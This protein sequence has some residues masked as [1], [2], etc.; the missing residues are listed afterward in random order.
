MWQS[1]PYACRQQIR[2]Q[3]WREHTAHLAAGFV[4]ANLVVVPAA[5]ADDFAQFCQANAQA[6]PLLAQT[7]PGQWQ[8]PHWGED[9]DLRQ[10]VPRYRVFQHGQCIEQPTSVLDIWQPDWVSF[11]L[12]CSFSFD[13]ALAEAGVPPRHWQQG[14]NVPMYI[15]HLASQAVGPF[16]GPLVV[17]MRPYRAEQVARVLEVTR[18]CPRVHGAPLQ[19]GQPLSLGIKDLSQPDFGE[20]VELASD[21][22]PLFWA[23][24]VTPQLALQQA[25]LPIAVTHSPGCMLITDIPQ[26]QLQQHLARSG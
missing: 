22:L 12:G 24:G 1:H 10:D 20:E 18:Q 8:L 16:R 23:C 25:R 6:C 19:I 3:C 26:R 14:R 4:Q 7:E 21:E 15:T 2:Q 5:Y 17:S 9:I 11:L 13:A